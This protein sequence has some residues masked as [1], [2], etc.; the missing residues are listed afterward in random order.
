[1]KM[2]YKLEL[3]NGIFRPFKCSTQ[4]NYFNTVGILKDKILKN[5]FK[6][7]NV[8]GVAFIINGDGLEYSEIKKKEDIP[9]TLGIQYYNFEEIR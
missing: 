5:S 3:K 4:D 7:V 8:L 6:D 1:M 9:S 2:T